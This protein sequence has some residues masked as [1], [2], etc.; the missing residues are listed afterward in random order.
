MEKTAILGQLAVHTGIDLSA[1]YPAGGLTSLTVAKR[2]RHGGLNDRESRAR[3]K[4]SRAD[5]AV[6]LKKGARP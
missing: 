2:V 1:L 4:F 5:A 6:V 3:S